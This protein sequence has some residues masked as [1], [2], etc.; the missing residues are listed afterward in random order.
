MPR[1]EQ[2]TPKVLVCDLVSNSGRTVKGEQYY[3]PAG[4]DESL[5]TTVETLIKDLAVPQ[6]Y[7][8]LLLRGNGREKMVDVI[9]RKEIPRKIE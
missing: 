9:T 1:R 7:D 2:K 3:I 5:A 6:K 4:T 8:R